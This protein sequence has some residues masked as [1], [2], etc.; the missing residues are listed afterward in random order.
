MRDACLGYGALFAPMEAGSEAVVLFRIVC[1][2]MVRDACGTSLHGPDNGPS[3]TAMNRSTCESSGLYTRLA[4][5]RVR[6]NQHRTHT[7]HTYTD[8]HA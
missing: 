2:S 3:F 4:V 1:A 8:G 7:T 5:H 6:E